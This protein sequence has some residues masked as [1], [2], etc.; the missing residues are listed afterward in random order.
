MLIG[1]TLPQTGVDGASPEAIGHVAR[2]A[3]AIGLDSLWVLDRLLR[4]VGPVA[5]APGAPPQELPGEYASVFDPIETLTYAAALTERVR[6]GTSAVLALFQPPVLLAK[7]LATLDRL[8]GGRVIAGLAQGWMEDEFAV[9]GV[10]PVRRGAG[11]EEYVAALRAVWAPDPVRS[12]GRF[13]RIPE[14]EIGPKPARPAGIPLLVGCYADAAID[15]AARIADGFNPYVET[16]DQLEHQVG[17]FRAAARAAG[18]DADALPV[19]QRADAR[20]TGTPLPERDLPP[21][22]GAADQWAADLERAAALGVG[23]V[24]FAV[25]GPIAARLSALAALRRL[26]P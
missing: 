12:A 17:R 5:V 20:P 1:M 9:A 7:R 22:A 21:F 4:P 16:W 8:S 25:E 3:E 23:H 15:R 19:V 13:Y 18:R 10:P 24:F 11:F 2:E 14:A 26:V 6:L